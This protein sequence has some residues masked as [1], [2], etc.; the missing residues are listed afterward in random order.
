MMLAANNDEI[1]WMEEHMRVRKTTGMFFLVTLLFF[2]ACTGGEKKKLYNAEKA[3]FEARRLNDE[4]TLASMD[5]EFLGRTLESYRSVV[6]NYSSY[7]GKIDG[8]ETVIVSAQ[9]ELAE[10]EFRAELL[11]DAINDFRKAYTLASNIPK[12]RANALWS[13]AYLSEQAGNHVDAI[14]LFEQFSGE[15]LSFQE[16]GKTAIMNRRY[17][18]VPIRLATLYSNSLSG[19]KSSKWLGEAEKLYEHII[20]TAS[21]SSLIREMSFN[22]ITACLQGQKWTKAFDLIQK[23]EETYDNA[24]DLPPLLFLKGK[25]ELNG[26]A[27]P[28]RAI[29]TFE[30]I[31]EN[32]PGSPEAVSALL[33][34][35]GIHLQAERLS[36]AGEIYSR[37]IDE[38][39]DTDNG[40]TEATWQL[41]N[42][43]ESEGKWID[44]SLYYKSVYT[45]FPGTI[46]GMESPLRIASHFVDQGEK[47]AADGAFSKAMEHYQKLASARYNPGIRI[48]AEEYYVR[49]LTLQGKWAEAASYLLSLPA[50]YP[51][52]HKFGQSFLM[53]ASIHEN[54]LGDTEKA[55]QILQNCIERY[56]E[57][58]L[59]DEAEKQIKR[60]KELK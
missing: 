15:F 18:L 40:V 1:T 55:V 51:D 2:I 58:E 36:K 59:A 38:H 24:A 14:S 16:A 41:A 60:I 13:S 4:L 49:A 54:E 44:A 5:R 37:I 39:E 33:M 27:Q 52:Y 56:A 7:S 34:V 29:K 17:L 20:T 42:I 57:T 19:A 12:A 11:K 31:D 25:I 8:M 32:Y 21:D 50:K 48:M 3:L 47:N 10:L 6:N 43:A 28:A 23:M 30:S 45:R 9:I 26:F 46:Q 35:A 53:A 22:L